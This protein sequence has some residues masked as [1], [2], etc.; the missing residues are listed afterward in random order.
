MSSAT[1][2]DVSGPARVSHPGTHRSHRRT[3]AVAD[4]RPVADR[5]TVTRHRPPQASRR[6]FVPTQ[7]RPRWTG[8]QDTDVMWAA[9]R[10]GDL[11]AREALLEQYAPLVSAVA[12]RLA[13][14]MPS[15]VEL[16]DLISHGM[17][18]LIDALGKFDPAH[19]AAFPTYAAQRIRGA[20]V[21]GLRGEDWVPRSVRTK[22]RAVD[23]ATSGLR[24]TLGRNPTRAEVA[25][26]LG[27]SDTELAAT[28]ARMS[29]VHLLPLDEPLGDDGGGQ[30]VADT[31]A[32]TLT[33]GP[34]DVVDAAATRALLNDAIAALPE[35]DKLLVTLYYFENLTLAEIGRV[36]AVTESRVSQLHT[37]AM[38]RLRAAL[39]AAQHG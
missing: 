36:L 30:R 19:G 33:A 32:D 22:A 7:R 39:A 24:A 1:L 13:A 27:V 4:S 35:R 9:F 23:Q 8:P 26:H 3:A 10:D 18:G 34:A 28:L 16:G 29:T 21:D 11:T 17:F 38:R 14:T 6:E 15:T 31:L 25:S 20:V 12:A 2:D 5:A 37:S